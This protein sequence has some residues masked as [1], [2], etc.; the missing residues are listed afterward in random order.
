[1]TSIL[2]IGKV[3]CGKTTLAKQI[4]QMNGFEIIEDTYDSYKNPKFEHN[5]IYIFHTLPQILG[6]NYDKILKYIIDFD[7]SYNPQHGHSHIGAFI[8]TPIIYFNWRDKEDVEYLKQL[9]V[10]KP[11]DLDY[12]EINN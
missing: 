3:G 10:I 6:P 4:Q 1:M 11:D 9:G 8:K 12:F 2:L 7:T 5:K